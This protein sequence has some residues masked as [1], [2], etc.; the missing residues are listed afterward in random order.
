MKFMRERCLRVFAVLFVLAAS[1]PGA[2]AAEAGNLV[3]PWREGQHYATLPIPVA[4]EDDAIVVTEF[5]SYACIHCFQFDPDIDNWLEEQPA[6]VTFERI[7]AVFNRQWE[8]FARAYYVARAC[9]VLDATHT[10]FFQ[11]I[12]L[13]RR[14]FVSP[15]D[16][17]SFYAQAVRAAGVGDGQCS[18]P[19]D[20]LD[21][22]DSFG[23]GAAVQQ[24][25]ARGRAYQARGVPTMIVD[26]T[27][28]TDGT[29]AGSNEAMLDVVDHL[30]RRARAAVTA[31]DGETTGP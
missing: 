26:G 22:F 29:S 7:P 11:A 3:E 14:R 12:H 19:Q 8:L 28:R 2:T 6:D 31:A 24:S 30:V 23:V 16:V 18:S 5:F 15:E 13:D 25:I 21:V 9:D 4:S 17:A 1:A 20:F 10:A 27:W